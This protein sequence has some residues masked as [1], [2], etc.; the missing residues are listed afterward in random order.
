MMD[1]IL[2]LEPLLRLDDEGRL[3][4]LSQVRGRQA[5]L[6]AL[7]DRME[8]NAIDPR[9]QTVFLCHGDCPE[10]AQL[11]AQM[12]RD[13]MGVQLVYVNCGGPAFGALAGPDALGLFY[14][15][16]DR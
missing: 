9:E 8:V 3:A 10:D 12:I 5:A 16:V 15:G 14:M 4:S 11:V 1:S 6:R 7:V 13:R 2:H